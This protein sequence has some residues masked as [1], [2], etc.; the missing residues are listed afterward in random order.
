M[1]DSIDNIHDLIDLVDETCQLNHS[2]FKQENYPAVDFLVV[3][4]G[5]HE[6][7]I[8]AT[9]DCELRIPICKECVDSL[10][11]PE[12]ILMICINCI[13]S[14]WIIR[15]LAK[16]KYPKEQH[17]VWLDKCCKCNGERNE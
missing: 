1:N 12:W 16:Y 2:P 13:S 14:Q 15:E 4:L 10:S 8:V 3:M 9:A 7:E 17:I 6:S 11:S 5:K